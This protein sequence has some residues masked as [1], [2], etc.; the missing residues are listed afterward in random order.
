MKPC[1][2][3]ALV[4]LLTAGCQSLQPRQKSGT[5]FTTD[6]KGRAT[7]TTY[8]SPEEYDRMTPE[9]RR[10]QQVGMGVEVSAQ[11]SGAKKSEPVSE[12][13]LTKAMAGNK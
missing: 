6:G 3:L 2:L 9:E 7:A 1:V 12:D 11:L 13:D 5:E 8:V 10:Q 4:A